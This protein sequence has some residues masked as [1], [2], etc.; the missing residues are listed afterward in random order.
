MP[1]AGRKKRN[2]VDAVA[3]IVVNIAVVVVVFG[4]AV[5]VV[6]VV[7]NVVPCGPTKT[8]TASANPPIDRRKTD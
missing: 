8:K 2:V 5:M 4:V 3:N 1:K 6:V 7:A